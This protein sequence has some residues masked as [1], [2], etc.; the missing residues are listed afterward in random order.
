MSKKPDFAELERQVYKEWDNMHHNAS[1]SAYYPDFQNDYEAEL[2][3]DIL[4]DETR[5][6]I[7]DLTE[8]IKEKYGEKLTFYAYGRNGATIAPHE[9]MRSIGGN[10]FGCLKGDHLP[11]QN[12]LEGYNELARVLRM[13]REINQ[14]WNAVAKGIPEWWKEAKEANEWQADIDA[15]EGMTKH[16]VEVWK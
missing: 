5:F 1:I 12:G 15:H 9:Y 2:F 14:Y 8:W 16:M 11:D 10:G 6:W 3:W 13:F 4:N 7:E